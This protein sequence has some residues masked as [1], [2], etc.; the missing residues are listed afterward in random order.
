MKNL[1]RF[2]SVE[3]SRQLARASVPSMM[4]LWAPYATRPR[5]PFER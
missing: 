1:K 4:R 3:I 2:Q 5:N